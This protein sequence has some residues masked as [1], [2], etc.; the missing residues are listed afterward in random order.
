MRSEIFFFIALFVVAI[1]AKVYCGSD[2]NKMR[3]KTCT[4]AQ[5]NSACL[6]NANEPSG[7]K[8]I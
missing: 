8:F 6:D 1:Q 5:Q 3:D 4:F 2:Y 7:K